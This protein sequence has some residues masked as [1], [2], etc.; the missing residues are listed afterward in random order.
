MSE[1]QQYVPQLWQ[2]ALYDQFAESIPHKYRSAAVLMLVVQRI[3]D[4]K[5]NGDELTKFEETLLYS[6]L[7]NETPQEK[8]PQEVAEDDEVLL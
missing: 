7:K 5:T 4:R 2:I 1:E 6:W 3:L 8:S